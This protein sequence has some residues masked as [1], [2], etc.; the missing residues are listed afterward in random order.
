MLPELHRIWQTDFMANCRNMG[1][2]SGKNGHNWDFFVFLALLSF[3]I[4]V[5]SFMFL[6]YF[7]AILEGV[8]APPKIRYRQKISGQVK[9][10]FTT[11]VSY[12]LRS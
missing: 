6:A 2:K 10:L 7:S 8:E 9:K 11:T 1:E 12:L 4:I 3:Y 5:P